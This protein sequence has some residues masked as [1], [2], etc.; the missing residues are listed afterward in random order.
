MNDEQQDNHAN[1]DEN[2]APAPH[3]PPVRG[4][5]PSSA[6]VHDAASHDAGSPHTD[7]SP[8]RRLAALTPIRLDTYPP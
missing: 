6:V 1:G 8:P 5:P 3:H 2:L 4:P 7:A